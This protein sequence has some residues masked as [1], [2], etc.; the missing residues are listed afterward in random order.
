MAKKL[1]ITH[2]EMEELYNSLCTDG[3]I[4][5]HVPTKKGQ[6]YLNSKKIDN[7]IILSAGLSTRFVPLNFEKPKSLL[8]VKG[9]ILIERQIE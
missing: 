4:K 8:K 3:Y 6:D 5:N 7:A 1:L 2:D 9:E